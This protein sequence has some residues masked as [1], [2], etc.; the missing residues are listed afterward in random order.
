MCG[1]PNAWYN[2]TMSGDNGQDTSQPEQPVFEMGGFRYRADYSDA[3]RY[4]QLDNGAIFDV[5][6]NHIVANPIGGPATAIT[7]TQAV[8]LADRRWDAYADA[9][10]DAI[11]TRSPVNT[12]TDAYGRLVGVAYDRALALETRTGVEWA[13]FVRS[14]LGLDMMPAAGSSQGGLTVH[15]SGDLAMRIAERLAE[16]ADRGRDG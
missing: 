2:T 11:A 14:G 5:Q 13:K 12:A 6:F 10:A 9:A 16:L 4:R 3:S 7:K 8:A 1:V 15:F